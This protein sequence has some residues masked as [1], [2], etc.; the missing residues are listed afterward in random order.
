ML[1]A[2]EHIDREAHWAPLPPGPWITHPV[3]SCH[4][5]QVTNRKELIYKGNSLT[6]LA[7]LMVF[8]PSLLLLYVE[9]LPLIVNMWR[10]YFYWD[11]KFGKGK[12]GGIS[13]AKLISHSILN[14]NTTAACFMCCDRWMEHLKYSAILPKILWA[15][16]QG[17]WCIILIFTFSSFIRFWTTL[18]IFLCSSNPL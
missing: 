15:Q 12:K 1:L 10:W 6:E 11:S 17:P 14:I 8:F 4:T 13:Y 3:L 9:N 18:R 16:A 7:S 2:R 5:W